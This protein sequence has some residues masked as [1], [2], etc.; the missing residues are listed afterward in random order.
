MKW[1]WKI[2]QF[3]EEI[4]WK[5]YT[6][7]KE[8]KAY[9]QWKKAYWI[10]FL[11]QLSIDHSK[12]QSPILDIGSGPA[13]IFILLNT[14]HQVH[15]VDPLYQEYNNLPIYDASWY[16][17]TS[18]FNNDW[19]SFKPQQLYTSIFCLNAINHFQ[20]LKT[21]IQKIKDVAAP[22]A[23]IV[24]SIDAH[25][26]SFLKFLFRLFPFDILHPHQYDLN[27]Y[28]QLF[29]QAGFTIVQEKCVKKE[30]IFSYWVVELK[31]M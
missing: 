1:R 25:N 23:T 9:L 26:T 28:R 24:I 13:G 4:W 14:Q 11:K 6:K 30:R 7:K 17:N 16:T 10:T 22:S 8:P 12:L 29:E 18:F 2:A 15:A 5:S 19:E 21:S 20:D 3:F 31:N 27:E